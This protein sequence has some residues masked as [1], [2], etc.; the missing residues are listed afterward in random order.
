MAIAGSVIITRL[1]P[2]HVEASTYAL[3]VGVFYFSSLFLRDIVGAVIAAKLGVTTENLDRY[4]TLIMIQLVCTMFAFGYV[5]I[6]PSNADINH[7]TEVL[8]KL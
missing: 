2:H 6:L 7:L 5:F 4:A 8:V 1:S 3:L